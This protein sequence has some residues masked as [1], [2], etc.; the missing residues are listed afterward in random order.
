MAASPPETLI[1]CTTSSGHNLTPGMHGRAARPD[2]YM[3]AG[4]LG[5]CS[6]LILH[7][8]ATHRG[9]DRASSAVR[10]EAANLRRLTGLVS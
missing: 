10:N 5:W 7:L 8:E 1:V 9:P 2:G 3:D 4:G 6:V